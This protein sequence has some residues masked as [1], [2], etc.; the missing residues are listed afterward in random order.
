MD[1]ANEELSRILGLVNR[2]NR[3]LAL[4]RRV[5]PMLASRRNN[6]SNNN[7]NNNHYG[8]KR[9][10]CQIEEYCVLSK[11]GVNRFGDTAL[12][13]MLALH[14]PPSAIQAFLN[15]LDRHRHLLL[16]EQYPGQARNHR[17]RTTSVA[18]SED[19]SSSMC[20]LYQELPPP[21]RLDQANLKG[22]TA[23][24]VAVHRNS[25]HAKEVVKIL[26]EYESSLA[27][28]P[29]HCGSYP[30]HILC[31]HN[32]TI[33][34]EVLRALLE[35]DPTIVLRDDKNGDNPLSLLW[36]NVL[37]FRWASSMEQGETVECH[38]KDP[39]WMNVIT[40]D[41]YVEYSLLLIQAARS[42][43]IQSKGSRYYDKTKPVTLHEVCGMARCPPLLARIVLAHPSCVNGTTSSTLGD[44]GML[45]IHRAVCAV[46][47]TERFVPHDIALT[48]V[49]ELLLLSNPNSAAIVDGCG[50]LPLHH[51][52]E[53][54]R[55]SEPDLLHVLRA[56]PEALRVRDPITLLYPFMMV[57]ALRQT[58]IETNARLGHSVFQK[59]TQNWRYEDQVS[60][61]FSL[62][63]LCPEV[64]SFHFQ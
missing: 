40:P 1:Q 63:R 16:L 49:I 60:T 37:R 19:I 21:P 59:T 39:S 33:R 51:A 30:L 32:V 20:F 50:R 53:H 2:S 31:G 55:I 54:G 8:V 34:L 9:R 10:C 46:P 25:W 27:S 57:A 52:L 42:C 4:E 23:L 62:L 58:R 12:H 45:P 56:Y 35:A 5:S 47:V 17:P 43:S 28:I 15:H 41:R 61:A 14:A 22:V 44:F 64:V 11:M 18:H 24:H 26:L 13:H 6:N 29:M 7:N 36:K 3:Y 48:S 38:P